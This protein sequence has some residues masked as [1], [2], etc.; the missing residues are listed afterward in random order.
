MDLLPESAHNSDL[1]DKENTVKICTKD[2]NINFFK[3]ICKWPIKLM[4]NI[5]NQQSSG[6]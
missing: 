6:K 5:Q 3:K 2:Q 1:N 4:K